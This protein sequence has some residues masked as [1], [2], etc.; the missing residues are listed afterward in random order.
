[1]IA[2]SL[3][4]GFS[5]DGRR[6]L[7]KARPGQ[8]QE[9]VTSNGNG[10]VFE[11]APKPMA[12]ER[13]SYVY[14]VPPWLSG[15]IELCSSLRGLGWDFGRD[16]YIP[17]HTRPLERVP[18]LR[19][20]IVSFIRNYIALDLLE[21]LLK[22]FPGVG[23]TDGGSIFYPQLPLLQRY[24]VS[25]TIHIISGSCLITG[26][27]M[28]YDL[29]TIFCV[30]FLHDPPSS[31]PPVMDDP[32]SAD[33]LHTFW[34]KRWHQLFRQT[35]IVFGGYPGK[36]VAGNIGM[37]FGTFIASGLYHECAIYSMG[38]GFDYRVPLYFA[39]QGPLLVLER[40]WRIATGRRVGGWPGRLWVYFVILV[41]GQP[42]GAYGAMIQRLLA[43]EALYCS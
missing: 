35:F 29:L 7:E 24:A 32:W 31:W 43:H 18:F 40:V 17:K 25:T 8:I 33:S 13:P 9:S 11:K 42:M 28:C 1:M 30:A 20:T 2:K 19:A 36:F 16:V 5:R 41:A 21:W 15:A 39:A 37:V 26:F 22:F 12:I 34:S 3:E 6:K 14:F 4:F 23:S 27:W 10:S 38:S